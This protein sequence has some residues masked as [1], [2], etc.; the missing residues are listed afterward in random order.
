MEA[1]MK[2]MLDKKFKEAV[3]GRA[4]VRQ[5]F[6]V[7]GVG[8]VAGCY[9]TDG[10]MVRNCLVRLLRDGVVIHEG[11]LESLKRFKDDVREVAQGYECGMNI[12]KYNDLKEG[13]HIEG[14][15]MEEIV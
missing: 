8:T 7:T 10:K 15:V 1:A 14:Y 4:E 11:Q 6:K 3:L 5:V 12:E 13:D 9:I 2:G